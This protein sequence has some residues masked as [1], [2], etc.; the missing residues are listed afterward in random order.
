MEFGGNG[1]TVTASI[2]HEFYIQITL[3]SCFSL[4]GYDRRDR[5]VSRF[6][7]SMENSCET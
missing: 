6:I 4:L 1:Q 3:P 2:M 7:D 5:T